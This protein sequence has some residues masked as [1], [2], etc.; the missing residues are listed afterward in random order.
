MA[1][2]TG[3]ICR[4]KM[5]DIEFNLGFQREWL[6]KQRLLLIVIFSQ[7]V[8]SFKGLLSSSDTTCD[9][10][11]WKTFLASPCRCWMSCLASAALSTRIRS[12][13]WVRSVS[14]RKSSSWAERF[15]PYD[16]EGYKKMSCQ[17]LALISLKTYRPETIALP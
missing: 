4:E 15:Q 8:F 2:E 14:A 7:P 10:F 5:P 9:E 1:L 12:D 17:K 11:L 16:A 13:R 3:Q 6:N